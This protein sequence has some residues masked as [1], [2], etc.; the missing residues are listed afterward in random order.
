MS[1][2]R[3]SRW[4]CSDENKATSAPT[5]FRLEEAYCGGQPNDRELIDILFEMKLAGLDDQLMK[6]QVLQTMDN[7]ICLNEQQE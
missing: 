2:F 4:P 7:E 1:H 3:C 5:M 6:K